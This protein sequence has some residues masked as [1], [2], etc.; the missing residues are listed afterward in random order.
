[1]A[2]MAVYGVVARLGGDDIE[3]VDSRLAVDSV[4]LRCVG[5]VG[6]GRQHLAENFGR[7]RR[8]APQA[9]KAQKPCRNNMFYK[10]FTHNIKIFFHCKDTKK[11]EN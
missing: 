6:H 1:M 5:I 7:T 9:K 4:P 3:K 2:G 11:K 8:P 10:A